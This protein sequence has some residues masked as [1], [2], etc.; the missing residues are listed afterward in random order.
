MFLA[1]LV[2]DKELI[3]YRATVNLVNLHDL[4][5][6]LLIGKTLCRC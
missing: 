2:F 3:V 1:T 4:N 5:S 6:S